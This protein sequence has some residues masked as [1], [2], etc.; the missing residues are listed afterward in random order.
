[1]LSGIFGI[2]NIAFRVFLRDCIWDLFIILGNV[3]CHI[4]KYTKNLCV[5]PRLMQNHSSLCAKQNQ[6]NI[7]RHICMCVFKTCDR[8]TID[9]RESTFELS[10]AIVVQLFL[11]WQIAI[12]FI[13]LWLKR[14][15]RLHT[16][17]PWCLNNGG[18]LNFWTSSSFC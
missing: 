10:I 5:F 1:M 4:L 12:F 17:K 15:R 9:Q 7:F 3:Y 18:K 11:Y 8:K 14:S 16:F 13:C 6:I 2:L